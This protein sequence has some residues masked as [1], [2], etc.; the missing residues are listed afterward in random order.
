MAIELRVGLVDG[1]ADIRFGRRQVID[2]QP[3]LK[4]VFED[5][6]APDALMRAP[7][8]LI[9]VMVIDHRLR[10]GDGLWLTSRLIERYLADG[11]KIPAII[12]TGAYYTDE[13]QLACIRA[14]ATDL[15]TQDT[16]PEEL[17]KAI[18]ST[19]AKS[20]EP[21]FAA[22]KLFLQRVDQN[23]EASSDFLLRLGELSDREAEVLDLFA[24]GVDQVEVAARLETP[25]YRV[26]QI[27][28][29]A[30]R[31]CGFATLAQLFLAL[32]ES[33]RLRG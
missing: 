32:Y 5:S 3:D 21:D 28:E 20:D 16:S 10:G 9:D 2:S 31:K 8:A 29:S 15:V 7:E 23:R 30:Q 6:S 1:N 27:L 33:D 12:T 25:K 18:R 24:A 17:L 22:L 4:V 19:A 26:R 11:S 14:G 13:L